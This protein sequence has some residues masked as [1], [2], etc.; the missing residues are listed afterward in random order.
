MPYEHD[1]KI[2]LITGA[3]YADVIVPG[4]DAR[5]QGCPRLRRQAVADSRNHRK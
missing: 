2:S 4:R 1:K 5:V 3:E